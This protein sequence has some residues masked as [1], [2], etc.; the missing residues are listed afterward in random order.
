MHLACNSVINKDEC[1]VNPVYIL[2]ALV[3]LFV[4][5][6]FGIKASSSVYATNKQPNKNSWID[7]K[8]IFK[9]KK[10]KRLCNL[11]ILANKQNSNEHIKYQLW[12]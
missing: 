11:K 1:Y 3:T 12:A 8:P 9:E 6:N 10:L 4:F 7:H 5:P 2:I